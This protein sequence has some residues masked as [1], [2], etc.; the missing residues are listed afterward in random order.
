MQPKKSDRQRSFIYPDL[1]EQLAPRNHFD[2]LAKAIPWRV[3]EEKF[4]PLYAFSGRPEKPIRLM[5]LLKQ[6]EDL[7]DERVVEAW[8]Q[9]SYFQTL[10]VQRRPTW[11]L[12]CNHSELTYA[13]SRIREYEVRNIFEVSVVLLVFRDLKRK[14]SPEALNKRE[15]L[16]F[17]DRVQ[18]QQRSETDKIFSLHEPG[19]LL[20]QQR[21]GHKKYEFGAKS[22]VTV[23][24]TSGII[25]WAPD[26]Q[27]QS[28]QQTNAACGS[29]SSRNHRGAKAEHGDLRPSPPW[30]A[31]NWRNQYRNIRFRRANKKISDKQ[32]ASERFR[33][34]ATIEPIISH[35]KND[36]RMLRNYLKGNSAPA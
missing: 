10:C 23:A 31:Q 8:G 35:I 7:S 16:D 15:D 36:N 2:A 33:S 20:P 13:R 30:E 5:V 17:Y 1:L 19:S 14:R 27:G 26:F 28:I 34:S 12:L 11:K 6:R 21:Q 32:Q 4:R 24:K 9:N 3:F 18:R 22:S 25:V 29:I